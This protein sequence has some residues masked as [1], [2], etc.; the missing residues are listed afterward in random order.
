MFSDGVDGGQ[1]LSPVS[2]GNGNSSF[3]HNQRTQNENPKIA[4]AEKTEERIRKEGIK[5]E[6]KRDPEISMGS[7]W[8]AVKRGIWKWKWKK[9]SDGTGVF[10]GL[11]FWSVSELKG[12]KESEIVCF[13]RKRLFAFSWFSYSVW[14]VS[15]RLGICWINSHHHALKLWSVMNTNKTKTEHFDLGLCFCL[16]G[17][18]KSESFCY[19]LCWK[20]V[21]FVLVVGA[22]QNSTPVFALWLFL[23]SLSFVKYKFVK[24]IYLNFQSFQLGFVLLRK[25]NEIVDRNGILF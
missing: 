4:G 14:F 24:K 2:N 6:K 11:N 10:V 5:E 12:E 16:W 1:G 7:P 3:R 9:E 19:S 21:V 25:R 17:R 22:R 20:E 8:K 23:F 15:L 18:R 13:K